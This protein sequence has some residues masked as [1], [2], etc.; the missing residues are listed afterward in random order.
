M[1]PYDAIKYVYVFYRNDIKSQHLGVASK[2][3]LLLFDIVINTWRFSI[4]L[5]RL[6]YVENRLF[7]NTILTALEDAGNIR[8]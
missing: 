1:F 3:I 2:L 7:R 6:Q 4:G 5:F 8:T